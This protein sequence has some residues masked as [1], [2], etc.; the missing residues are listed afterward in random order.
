MFASLKVFFASLSIH[1]LLEVVFYVFLDRSV[2]SVA[3]DPRI[4]ANLYIFNISASLSNRT[5]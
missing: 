2:T 5:G 3:I 4:S 1:A